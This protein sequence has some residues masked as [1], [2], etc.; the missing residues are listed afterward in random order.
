MRKYLTTEQFI[1]KAKQ[2]H[3]D[4]YNYSKV[5]YINSKIPVEIIC[6]SHGS[7]FKTPNAHL[8]QQSGCPV[9]SGHKRCFLELLSKS[10]KI[11]Q[12]KYDYSKFIFKNM[13]TKS[14]IICPFHGEFKQA[15]SKHIYQKT[16]CAKCGTLKAAKANRKDFEMFVNEAK[17]IHNEKYSYEK[18]TYIN[19]H[20]PIEII[21]PLH[22][23]FFQSPTNHIHHHNQNGC[24]LCANSRYSKC[25]IEWLCSIAK[26]ENINIQHAE[27]GGE[28]T[29]PGTKY[30]VDGY[31][32]ETNTIYEF[33]G[34]VFHGNLNKFEQ[35][36]LCHPF[37]NETA[38]ELYNK[39]IAREQQI[40]KMGYNIIS[41]WEE[42]WKSNNKNNV[43]LNIKK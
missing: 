31:C 5:K 32:K 23:S 18:S 14:I 4:K 38:I 21:C 15:M 9:C 19:I 33:Y 7:F 39:T 34:D 28:Y 26:H 20:T 36:E 17:K 30:R 24:P 35:H 25:A 3:K 22:G 37:T 11:H 16:G 10:H 1:R 43:Y 2:I 8:S 6:P 12:R 40:I 42:Q 27:N 29:I 13:N 41:I